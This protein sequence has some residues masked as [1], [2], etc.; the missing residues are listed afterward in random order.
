M[1]NVVV[2]KDIVVLLL[3]T[4]HFHKDVKKDMVYVL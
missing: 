3:A 1:V 2:K 4:A